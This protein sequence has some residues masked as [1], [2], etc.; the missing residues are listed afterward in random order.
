MVTRSP[1]PQIDTRG[2][3]GPERDTFKALTVPFKGVP[4]VTG[5]G[6][7]Y[8]R[9]ADAL[10]QFSNSIDTLG[11]L[12]LALEKKNKADAMDAQ[13]HAAL[14]EQSRR[15][16]GAQNVQ[17]TAITGQNPIGD[18]YTNIN[19]LTTEV[20]PQFGQNSENWRKQ[21][22]ENP[23]GWMVDNIDQNGQPVL[24]A[25]GQP[26]KR[27]MTMADIDAKWD[28][29]TA[30]A[31]EKFANSNVFDPQ[32]RAIL[33]FSNEQR[34]KDK[35]AFIKNTEQYMMTQGVTAAAG[36]APILL[37][38]LGSDPDAD[39]QKLADGMSAAMAR[40]VE[41]GSGNVVKLDGKQRLAIWKAGLDSLSEAAKSDPTIAA[42]LETMLQSGRLPTGAPILT[43]PQLSD[44]A[45]SGLRVANETLLKQLHEEDEQKAAALLDDSKLPLNLTLNDDVVTKRTSVLGEEKALKTSREDI[46]K[47]W[48]AG[49]DRQIEIK[50]AQGKLSPE[51]ILKQKI[52]QASL[53][54][55]VSPSIKAFFEGPLFDPNA[56]AD[57]AAQDRLATSLTLYQ[58]LQQNAPLSI[59]DYIKDEKS[60]K[61]LAALDLMSQ[62]VGGKVDT[63][64]LYQQLQA[65]LD[66]DGRPVNVIGQVAKADYD[67][68]V[69]ND[70]ASALSAKD[71]QDVRD[72]FNMTYG[73]ERNLEDV[74][75]KLDAIADRVSASAYNLNGSAIPL[76]EG[77]IPK[78]VNREKFVG[79]IDEFVSD[80]LKQH[81][82]NYSLEDVKPV[83]VFGGQGFIL[84]SRYDDRLV[85]DETG[86][87]IIINYKDVAPHLDRKYEPVR[88]AE[89]AKRHNSIVELSRKQAEDK[90]RQEERRARL[91]AE[92]PNNKTRGKLS[93]S[94]YFG[95]SFKIPSAR[96]KD[97]EEAQRKRDEAN[98]KNRPVLKALG[99]RP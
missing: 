33:A 79:Q 81:A 15:S 80:V 37:R 30:Q 42:D 9:L 70:K 50:G 85:L 57:P 3:N 98:A 52:Q 72:I 23:D 59:H 88:K 96:K 12:G 38:Q 94:E 66:D 10:G 44:S 35:E 51:T 95:F 46:V 36:Q 58:L 27:R 4:R 45:K 40:I 77:S 13:V 61:Y 8:R 82:P 91:R 29:F 5:I 93:A 43:H 64:T 47:K 25:E 19:R 2:L 67:S 18:T 84:K 68:W 32:A 54:G 16:S 31:T 24:D 99:F 83:P 74:E 6:E 26:T 62:S 71:L 73:S 28:T 7:N 87:K 34:Q 92:Y 22:E 97:E 41:E 65:N 21:Q 75:E 11:S 89:A 17:T 76:P 55:Y 53:R 48:V 1:R 78:G 56:P 49:H 14:L 86:Q 60:R 63:A 20:L 39:G 90:R 69:K